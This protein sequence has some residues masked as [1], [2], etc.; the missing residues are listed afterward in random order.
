MSQ[1]LVLRDEHNNYLALHVT[2]SEHCKNNNNILKLEYLK[3]ADIN[4]V[5]M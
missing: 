4:Y 5:V 2:K 1:V 3:D